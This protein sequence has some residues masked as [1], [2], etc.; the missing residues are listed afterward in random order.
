MLVWYSP[1]A[2]HFGIIAYDREPGSVRATVAD[3]DNL[4]RDDTVTDLPRH[5]QRSSAR[6]LLHRQPARRPAG[7]R[8]ERGR[9]QRRHDVR[10]LDAGSSIDKN[11]DYDWDSH[12]R[13]TDD[14]LHGRVRIPF[15]SLRYPGNGAAEL[16]P[17]RPAQGPAH[18]LRGHVDRRPAGQ[19]ELPGQA[20]A[21][22]GLHDMK[23]GVVTELQPFVTDREQRRRRRTG[24]FERDE[25]T[26][27]RAPT[28][29]SGS[30]TCRS[31]PP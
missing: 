3:R 19:L 4:D 30:R 9:V 29:G 23:R 31:T 5:V 2:L 16:G 11:P 20:G 22:D 17:E 28:C 13:L 14:G 7:R 6:V 12:G 8:P 26:S 21:I 18:R 10:R 24:E 1:T 15:K 27:T 25:S